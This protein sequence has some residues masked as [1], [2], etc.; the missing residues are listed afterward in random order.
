MRRSW[1]IRSSEMSVSS[2]ERG[3]TAVG[4]PA[5]SLS[6][7]LRPYPVVA[8]S[9]DTAV[10][11]LPGPLLE[12]ARDRQRPWVADPIFVEFPLHKCPERDRARLLPYRQ[13]GANVLP[14]SVLLHF[15]PE[16]RSAREDPFVFAHPR[17][18]RILWTSRCQCQSRAWCSWTRCA[19]KRS[20]RRTG[21]N[22]VC[23]A[24]LACGRYS[25][26]PPRVAPTCSNCSQ[27]HRR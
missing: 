11:S 19:G 23:L 15:H 21:W 22:Y 25:G 9:D 16:L 13:S 26:G 6:I 14:G 8:R 24:E 2:S 12:V 4:R 10:L 17:A 20:P 3:K 1:G 18:P 7:I 27:E 5:G